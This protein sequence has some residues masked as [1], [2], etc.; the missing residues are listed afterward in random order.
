MLV[1]DKCSNVWIILAWSSKL[2]AFNIIWDN[3]C[4]NWH[5]IFHDIIP[6]IGMIT[7]ENTFENTS[8][9]KNVFSIYWK[10][11]IIRIFDERIQ[12]RAFYKSADDRKKCSLEIKIKHDFIENVLI[13]QS[14]FTR[15]SLMHSLIQRQYIPIWPNK[16]QWKY[17]EEIK[18]VLRWWK[19]YQIF[20]WQ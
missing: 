5:F 2:T 17:I 18:N 3:S 16:T 9:M 15:G 20:I 19:T 4:I 14:N 6:V 12:S 10:T 8:Q 1:V 13:M 11:I 7:S